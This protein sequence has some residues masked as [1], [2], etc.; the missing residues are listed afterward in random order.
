MTIMSMIRYFLELPTRLNIRKDCNEL[1]KK[2]ENK[3][4]HI[5]NDRE[6]AK[7]VLENFKH[8]CYE[9]IWRKKYQDSLT[10][11]E[12][13]RSRMIHKIARVIFSGK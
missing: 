6:R 4:A 3:Y 7:W 5:E 10:L 8:H 12:E 9:D 13:E 1:V 2:L 11:F